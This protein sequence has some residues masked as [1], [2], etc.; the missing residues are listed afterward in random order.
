[1][2][3]RGPPGEL[4][5]LGLRE[6]GLPQPQRVGRD[7]DAL[8][9][10]QEL[11]RTLERERARR[12][13]ADED[14]GRGGA[15]VGLVLLLGRVDVEVLGARVLAHDH[16]LVDLLAGADE[17]AAPVLEAVE[18]EARGGAGAVGDQGAG[19]AGAHLPGPRLP[20]LEHVVQQAGAAGL[21]EELGAEADQAARGRQIVEAYPAGRVVDHLLHPALAQGQHLGDDADVILGDVDRQP[22][23]RLAELAVDL[24]GQHAGLAR[25]QLEA[26][27]PHQLEQ[28][29]ELQL[30]AAV[31]LPGV[32]A[33][34]VAN[35]DG[36]VA[37]QLRIEPGADLA[38]R[39]LGAVAAGERR[40]VDADDDRQRGLVDRDHGQRA[41]ILRIGERLADRHLLDS[42][43]GDDLAR[44][45]LGG[46]DPV[47]RL[48][49]V[50][51]AERRPLDRAVGAT[52]GDRLPGADRPVADPAERQATD[53]GVGVE[54]G[55]VGLKRAP[56]GRTRAP[57]SARPS[58][59]AA[60]A[61]RCPARPG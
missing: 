38:R 6:L 37:D 20:A 24:A 49:Y 14:V 35:A 60:A 16:P 48:G 11:E 15:D 27:A 43:D 36:H 55:D 40:V 18:G 52:P 50:E 53:V 57:G 54:V 59:R 21:G 3:G 4:H 8:V 45:R 51:T 10:A 13:Q 25:R 47:E 30:A 34:R 42:G 23:D 26:L 19:G 44:A 41:R 58:G 29:D 9:G 31:D 2:V 33:L 12:D 28:H 46:L 1:M 39:Q 61:G 17:E 22:L 7:L 56:P 5:A 32:V